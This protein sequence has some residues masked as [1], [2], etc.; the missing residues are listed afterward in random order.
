MPL[1]AIIEVSCSKPKYPSRQQNRLRSL[2]LASRQFAPLKS[3]PN[4]R[5]K[6]HRRFIRPVRKK[7]YRQ[8]A[9]RCQSPF[10]PRLPK[11][12][13]SK[14]RRPRPSFRPSRGLLCAFLPKRPLYTPANRRRGSCGPNR[15]PHD[16]CSEHGHIRG[17]AAA[18]R[19]GRGCGRRRAHTAARG[20]PT[21]RSHPRRG[22][23]SGR[24]SRARAH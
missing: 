16:T 2:S 24:R 17:S 5:Q 19:R 6:S 4:R 18:D 21:G 7:K 8:R 10:R 22:R 23:R 9:N 20:T 3:R 14:V 1:S 12:G 13:P 15:T 11:R